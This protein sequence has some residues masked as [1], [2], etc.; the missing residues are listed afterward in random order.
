[1][2]VAICLEP[3]E[4]ARSEPDPNDPTK[5]VQTSYVSDDPR[6]LDGP[7]YGV[8]ENVFDEYDLEACSLERES[9]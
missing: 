3:R 4:M 5:R 9:D 7:P 6:D 8:V 2:V 1:M